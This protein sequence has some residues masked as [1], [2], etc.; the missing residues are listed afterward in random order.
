MELLNRRGGGEQGIIMLVEIQSTTDLMILY[1]M[2][3]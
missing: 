2:M 1:W 3:I